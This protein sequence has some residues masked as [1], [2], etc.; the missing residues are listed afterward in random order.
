MIRAPF[1][2]NEIGKWLAHCDDQQQAEIFNALGK[3]LRPACGDK[4]EMQLCYL[5]DHLDTHGEKLVE[6][7]AEFLKHRK[8]LE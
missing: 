1:N 7:L 5:S 8:G 4:V 2:C 6:A 3:E